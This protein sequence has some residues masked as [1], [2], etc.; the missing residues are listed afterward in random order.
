LSAGRLER[1]LLARRDAGGKCL[2]PYV[3]AGITG[4]WPEHVTAAEDGGA[5]AIE[6]GLPFSDPMLDGPIIQEASARALGRGVTVAG[7]LAELA[8]VRATVPLIV[9]TYSNI[10]R[11]HGYDGFCRRLAGAGVSGLIVADTPVDE[12]GPPLAAASGAGLELVMLVAPSTKPERVAR[13]GAASRGFVYAVSTMGVTGVRDTVSDS[14]AATVRRVRA[15]T[16]LPVL[17]GFGISNPEQAAAVA[18]VADGVVV[19][20]ALM[21]SVLAGATPADTRRE[22]AALRAAVDSAA[23]G[24]GAGSATG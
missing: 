10:V 5:D 18:R 21:R 17:V 2:V 9:M 3:T 6:I 20:S 23:T 16:R 4:R 11:R 8:G 13:I 24:S 15:C 19:A 12:V 1:A 7:L 22:V 14:V